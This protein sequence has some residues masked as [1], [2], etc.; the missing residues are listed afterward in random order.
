[1]PYE[2]ADF[3]RDRIWAYC[4][5]VITYVRSYHPTAVF[6]CSGRSMRTRGRRSPARNSARSTSMSTCPTSGRTPHM[7]SSISRCEG[8]DYDVWQKNSTLIRQV[9]AFASNI[10]GRPASER[11]FLSGLYG[12]PDPPMRKPTACGW[13]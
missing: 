12:P 11:T 10:L 13:A 2:T 4:Q 9:I 1:M 6:E 7:A 5:D 3:L 8:F